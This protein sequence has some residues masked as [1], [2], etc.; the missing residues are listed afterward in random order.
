MKYENKK[1]N[2]QNPKKYL[3]IFEKKGKKKNKTKPQKNPN[4]LSRKRK[5]KTKKQDFFIICLIF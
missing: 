1:K 5:K 2:T 3:I 4:S